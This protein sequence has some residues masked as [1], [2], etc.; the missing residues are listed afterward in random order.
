MPALRTEVTEIVTGLAMLGFPSLERALAVRP[1]WMRNV[2]ADEFDRLERCHAEGRY[3]VEFATAWANGRRFLASPDA[4]RGR[5][6]DRVE[7]KG[8]H[9]PPGYE[10][11]PADLRVDH[12]YLVSCKYGSEVLANA[13]PSHLFDRRLAERRVDRTDWYLQVAPEAYQELYRAC[14]DHLAE[15]GA[16]LD[17]DAGPWPRHV[18][19]LTPRHRAVL[20][21]AFRRRWPPAVAEVYQGF[22]WAVAAASADHWR[23][24]LSTPARRE[25]M[26]WRL[27]RLEA[28]PYFVLGAAVDASPLHYRTATP[29]DFRERHR[30]R[31]FDVWPDPVGQP[32]VRWRAEVDDR[33]R[34]EA[35]TTEGHVEIRWSHGRFAGVPEAKVYLDTPHHEV[36]GYEPI[37]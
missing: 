26:L 7:W 37:T 30:V 6:P 21:A 17:T 22:A 9:R 3:A 23:R 31:A 32:L 28:A 16:A 4:L 20:K 5:V 19:D 14:L 10:Q 36:A 27:L 11:L 13:G 8:P 34:G 18:G 24:R 29:W 2:G 15:T 1:D 25:E 35:R 33:E 12:V